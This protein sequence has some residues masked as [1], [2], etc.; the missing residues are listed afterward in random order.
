MIDKIFDDYRIVVCAGTG[1]VG[2]TTVSAAMGIAA[3]KQGKRV[4]VLTVDPARRLASALRLDGIDHQL[5]E[6]PLSATPTHPETS[7]STGADVKPEGSSEKTTGRLWI[8]MLQPERIFEHFIDQAQVSNAEKQRLKQNPLFQQLTTSLSGSQEFT[9]LMWLQQLSASGDYDLIILDTPP[10]DHAI[11]FLHAPERIAALFEGTVA[12]F[13]AGRVKKMGLFNQLLIGSTQVWLKALSKMTGAEFIEA[14]SDFVA[15]VGPFSDVIA[16]RSRAAEA[17]LKSD[18]TAFCLVVSPDPAKLRQGQ[19][20]YQDLREA[21]YHLQGLIIN[22][23][24]PRW[25]LDSP[26]SE[27]DTEADLQQRMSAF[28]R[29]RIEQVHRSALIQGSGLKVLEL[30][31]LPGT[32]A[33]VSELELLAAYLDRS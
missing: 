27:V 4:L 26:M 8:S 11:D 21:G 32:L 13:F 20:F 23:A 29:G 16:A 17:L 31:E 19:A 5:T 2:K 25:F 1:G 28:F 14:V 18:Q 15:S 10:S 9:S 7:S 6:I 24:Y 22:R 30:P 33:G 3:A 12:K